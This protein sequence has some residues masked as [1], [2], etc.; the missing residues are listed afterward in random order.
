VTRIPV[1]P[2]EKAYEELMTEEESLRARDVGSMYAVL[3]AIDTPHDL[4]EA[5]A[6]AP[7]APAGAYRSDGVE[8]MAADEV[9]AVLREAV[10]GLEP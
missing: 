8:P 10:D 4:V 6:H 5:Y 2:G 7:L 3:P 1:R 9:A